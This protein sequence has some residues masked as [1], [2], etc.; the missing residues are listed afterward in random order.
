MTPIAMT[1]WTL[2]DIIAGL[3]GATL[4]QLKRGALACLIARREWGGMLVSGQPT[5]HHPR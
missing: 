4:H 1:G 3:R 5:C 2:Q